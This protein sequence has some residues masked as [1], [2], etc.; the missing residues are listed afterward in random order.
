M[1]K[2]IRRGEVAEVNGKFYAYYEKL[3]IVFECKTLQAAQQV[4]NSNRKGTWHR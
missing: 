4:I 1:K 2:I 3:G